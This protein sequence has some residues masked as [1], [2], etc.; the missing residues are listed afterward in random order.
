MNL[1]NK[2][3]SSAYHK[4][5]KRNDLLNGPDPRFVSYRENGKD[6]KIEN[7]DLNSEHCCSFIG[8]M[9]VDGTG[10]YSDEVITALL[11]FFI[12]HT[13]KGE[14]VVIEL[15]NA[16][17][18]IMNGKESMDGYLNFEEQK[19]H[20]LGIAKEV[21]KKRSKDVEIIDIQDNNKRLFE[22][23]RKKSI[24][25]LKSEE[26]PDLS[27]EFDSLDIARHLYRVAQE[28]SKQ[29]A[30]E[31]RKEEQERKEGQGKKEDKKGEEEKKLKEYP[32]YIEE[33]KK[34]KS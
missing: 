3:V 23:L 6:K 30:E 29:K 20:M 4:V 31:K 5:S 34:L 24:E 14:K 15:A 27:K 1:L 32:K 7:L 11:K 26:L 8:K 13:Q 33:F 18:E 2:S 10:T 17:S 16:V 21:N 9:K 19:Q 25:G 28:D 12:D 22:I